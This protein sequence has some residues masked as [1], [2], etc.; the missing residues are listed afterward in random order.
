MYA[1][2]SLSATLY[3]TIKE[4]TANPTATPV[5]KIHTDLNVIIFAPGSC[6]AKNAINYVFLN[7]IL[8]NLPITTN[9][10]RGRPMFQHNLQ[11]KTHD[12]RLLE[13]NA[14]ILSQH[15][16][17]ALSAKAE[18]SACLRLQNCGKQLK[19]KF[20]AGIFHLWVQQQYF[21]GKKWR[22]SEQ[23]VIVIIIKVI[24]LLNAF[25]T[26]CKL[27]SLDRQQHVRL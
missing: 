8:L 5:I 2:T 20:C 27:N 13:V 21:P 10:R 17:D 14:Y 9:C 24:G 4:D 19:T 11:M 3:V 12:L 7:T 22:Y 18:I 16:S 6:P 25:Q 15:S 26:N 1:S 23:I